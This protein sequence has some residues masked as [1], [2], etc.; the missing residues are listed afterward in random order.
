MIRRDHGVC[1]QLN[2]H[3]LINLH[4]LSRTTQSDA[5]LN[6]SQVTTSHAPSPGDRR[7]SPTGLRVRVE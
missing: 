1:L 3:G 2:L 4:G 6:S 7:N 5:T